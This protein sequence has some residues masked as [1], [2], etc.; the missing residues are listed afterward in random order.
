MSPVRARS[1]ALLV[2][3]RSASAGG[4]VLVVAVA[5]PAAAPAPADLLELAH[6][7]T[8]LDGHA[9]AVRLAG[10]EETARRMRRRPGG[11]D[12]GILDRVQVD[13][14]PVRVLRPARRALD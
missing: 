6:D 3:R 10:E 4:E 8:A 12:V 14:A 5:R 11:G 7:D 2:S 13:R 9:W 1:P